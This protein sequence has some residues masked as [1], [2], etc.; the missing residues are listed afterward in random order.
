MEPWYRGTVISSVKDLSDFVICVEDT[1]AAAE[2]PCAHALMPCIRAVVCS[3]CWMRRN[4]ERG[5]SKEQ[6]RG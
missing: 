4:V 6:P 2:G 5:R 1:G 3:P